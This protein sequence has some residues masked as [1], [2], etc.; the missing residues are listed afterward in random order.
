MVSALSNVPVHIIT[1]FLGS[2][3]TSLIHSLIEQK[4]VDEKWAILV[5]EFGQIGIDQAMFEA[6]DDVVVKGLP[7]GCL[8]CQLAFVMQAALV[9]LLSRSQP[10]RVI[11]EPSGLGHP[12][13]LV[14]L[15]R[16]EA[17]QGVVDVRDIVTT[18]DPRRLDEPR[19]VDHETF[20]DQLEIADAIALTMR[21]LSTAEQLSAA[22][23][24]VAERWPPRK[25]VHEADHGRLPL[26]LLLE[27]DSAQ[28]NAIE[29][30]E[31]HQPL[32]VPPSL[33]G[34]FFDVPPAPGTPQCET[35]A[36]LGYAS[37]GLRWHPSDC[38]DLD[39]LAAYLSELSRDVRVKGVFHTQDGWRQLN[40]ADGTLSVTPS[41]W[42]QDSRLE[43][44]A[45]ESS[46]PHM[47]DADTLKEA[48][49][50]TLQS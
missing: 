46:S 8:C 17:F 42:R 9:N 14:D 43:I 44:I 11:I 15:L 5:N 23:A 29:T 41:T 40:R 31:A 30:P 37:I 16:S 28:R 2:G 36:S 47:P 39:G 1:G 18:L 6:R 38:F 45:H 21:D 26:S 3:K 22:H 50:G 4:P 27:S 33:D 20:R 49:A 32:P 13:G 10:D 12:A 25:W 35:G 34:G 48:L 7:G 24:F 19:V